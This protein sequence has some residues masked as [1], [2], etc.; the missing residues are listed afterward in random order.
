[1][2]LSKSFE[3]DGTILRKYD[4]NASCLR[5]KLTSSSI[6]AA[7]AQLGLSP[8]YPDS[9]IASNSMQ[10][11]VINV[12]AQ[13]RGRSAPPSEHVSID[14]TH[15]DINDTTPLLRADRGQ[16]SHHT[17]ART[18]PDVFTTAQQRILEDYQQLPISAIP[19]C[20][21]VDGDEESLFRQHSPSRSSWS[22]IRLWLP[23]G[24]TVA[25]I[26]FVSVLM[27]A[28]GGIAYGIH[29]LIRVIYT[30]IVGVCHGIAAGGAKSVAAIIGAWKWLSS[31]V[32]GLGQG[33]MKAE[34]ALVA[35]V[36]KGLTTIVGGWRWTVDIIRGLG[37][38]IM[39]GER[40][41]ATAAAKIVAAIKAVFGRL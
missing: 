22:A 34:H 38:G 25:A 2:N 9:P 16:Y 27:V 15:N 12:S 24:Q 14:T 19:V 18:R 8:P 1:M 23:S 30:A 29:L 33:F 28:A 39:R 21:S 5:Y 10:D 36:A 31:I 40:A 13:S 41:F 35:A 3:V 32:Q 20:R 37:Q 17:F 4:N 6:A 26:L 7:R 11:E